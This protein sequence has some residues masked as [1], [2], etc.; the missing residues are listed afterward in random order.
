MHIFGYLRGP[1]RGLQWSDWAYLALQVSSHPYLCTCEIRKQDDKY[2]LS[3]N[4]KY[5]NKN[6]FFIHI[7]LKVT[8]YSGSKTLSQSRQMYNKGKNKLFILL[9]ILGYSAMEA[10]PFK[11]LLVIAFH[12]L[13]SNDN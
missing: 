4:P 10:N 13:L 1:G 7:E 2:F 8:K 12:K 6:H 9:G 11:I 3:S 5:E